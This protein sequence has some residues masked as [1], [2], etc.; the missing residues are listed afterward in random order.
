MERIKINKY[1]YLDEFI[2]PFTYFNEKDHGLSK[3]DKKLFDIADFIRE[4]YG[5]ALFINN[6]WFY[7]IT[8]KNFVKTYDK[9][10]ERIEADATV[11]KWS[12]IRT[13]RC[14]IGSPIS[15]H[16]LGKAIDL[17]GDEKKLDKIV[18]DNLK[19]LHT[20]GLR[21]IEDISITKGWL[22]AD[23]LAK[24]VGEKEIRIITKTTGKNIKI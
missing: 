23:T 12:G 5:S 20:L 11:R 8:A 1:F 6:W 16:R 9:F 2:D 10:I 19:A 15:A 14:K 4:K 24:N 21:R 7:Y 3:I 17:K 22:H 13:E 18:K